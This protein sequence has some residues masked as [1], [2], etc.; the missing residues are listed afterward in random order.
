MVLACSDHAQILRGVGK[1]REGGHTFQ[2]FKF[3]CT[4][5]PQP[6]KQNELSDSLLTPPPPSVEKNVKC[7]DI[8]LHT[9]RIEVS[10]KIQRAWFTITG[11]I[12][13]PDGHAFNSNIQ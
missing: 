5:P 12:V 11:V 7:A 10:M 6:N 3:T 13:H 4:V 8:D 1:R 9:Y 2:N